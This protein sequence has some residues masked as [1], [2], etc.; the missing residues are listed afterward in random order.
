MVRRLASQHGFYDICNSMSKYFR[1]YFF[2][3][4]VVT[5][6][7]TVVGMPV[8][9]HYCGG[10]VEE[11]S[12]LVNDNGCCGDEMPADNDCCHDEG[13]VI[14]NKVDFTLKGFSA[15]FHQPVTDLFYLLP[16]KWVPVTKEISPGGIARVDTSPPFQNST[17]AEVIVLRI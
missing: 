4:L 10:E 15:Q 14:S 11:V 9:M 1:P 8:Y 6:F 17:L 7:L 13:L 12:Y 5:Y 2:A 16:G 3:A